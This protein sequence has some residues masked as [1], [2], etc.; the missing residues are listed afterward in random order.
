MKEKQPFDQVDALIQ[1]ALPEMSRI[2]HAAEV[3]F[4]IRLR[5]A[6]GPQ[7]SA[8]LLTWETAATRSLRVAAA[9]T[10]LIVVQS[11]FWLA[12]RIGDGLLQVNLTVERLLLGI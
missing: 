3:G 1:A 8:A 11:G 6:L 10:A 9:I 12:P 5:A 2:R 7:V 4:E